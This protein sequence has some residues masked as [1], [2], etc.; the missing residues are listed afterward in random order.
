MTGGSRRAVMPTVAP[1]WRSSTTALMA[2]PRWSPASCPSSTGMRPWGIRRWPTRSLTAWSRPRTRSPDRATLCGNGRR[3]GPEERLQHNPRRPSVAALR[4]WQVSPGVGGNLPVDWVAGFLWME[5]QASRGR[6][7]NLPMDWV[8]DIRGI[9]TRRHIRSLAGP[10]A[11]GSARGPRP[12]AIS[13][14]TSL[15]PQAR[16]CELSWGT[17]NFSAER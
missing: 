12:P 4:G 6:S 15:K 17:H 9:C 1:C 14:L 13:A 7:G 5:W 3:G 8:A 11:Q 16:V 2:G 10:H